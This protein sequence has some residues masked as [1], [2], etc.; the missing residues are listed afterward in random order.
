MA[1][2]RDIVRDERIEIRMSKEEKEA[3]YEYAKSIDMIP[4]RLARNI[5]MMQVEAKMENAIMNPFIKAYRQ[6][7]KSTNQD[8]HLKTE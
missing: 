8:L 3:F 2:K 1:F 6:Y 5:I 4:G 7:L